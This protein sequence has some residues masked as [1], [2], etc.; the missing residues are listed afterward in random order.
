MTYV[1]LRMSPHSKRWGVYDTR[2]GGRELVE[3]GFFT[4]SAALNC[5]RRWNRDV[6]W[7][8]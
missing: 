2:N 7:A 8:E 5:A 6:A 3:G 1:V 4:Y